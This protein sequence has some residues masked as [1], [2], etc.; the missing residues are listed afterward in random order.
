MR[1]LIVFSI[2]GFLI[3]SMF[4]CTVEQAEHFYESADNVAPQVQAVSAAGQAVLAT[5]AAELIPPQ[6]RALLWLITVIG[7]AAAGAY[8]DFRQKSQSENV[9]K[10][11]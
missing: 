11:N 5:P 7:S 8:Q 10:A 1:N 9:K 4:S 3:G 6:A 2:A